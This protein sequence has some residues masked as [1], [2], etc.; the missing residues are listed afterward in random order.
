MWGCPNRP[1]TTPCGAGTKSDPARI[2]Y[3]PSP[4][5]WCG[6]R[7]L[8]GISVATIPV[9]ESIVTATDRTSVAGGTVQPETAPSIQLT[10]RLGLVIGTLAVAVSPTLA[11]LEQSIPH[12]T[13]PPSEFAKPLIAFRKLPR[14]R[15][16]N[17]SPWPS[18][19]ERLNLIHCVDLCYLV[20]R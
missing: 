14:S 7:G 6:A 16:C 12:T 11:S 15:S 20:P 10:N 8:L 17:L 5:T 4:A 19:L 3:F 9:L 13:T 18:S 1:A 2:I